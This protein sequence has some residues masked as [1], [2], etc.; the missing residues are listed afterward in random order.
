V[1][2]QDL[3]TLLDWAEDKAGTDD[4]PGARQL[5]AQIASEVA[6]YLGDATPPEPLT[7]SLFGGP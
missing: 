7:Q 3:Q 4:D 5:W 6:A 1:A 2:N